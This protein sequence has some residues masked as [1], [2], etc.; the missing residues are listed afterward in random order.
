M[1]GQ[2]GPAL[3]NALAQTVFSERVKVHELLLDMAKLATTKIDRQ[4]LTVM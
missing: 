4:Q 3:V 1:G 2:T